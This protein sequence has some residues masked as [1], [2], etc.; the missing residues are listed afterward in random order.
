MPIPKKAEG[1]EPNLKSTKQELLDAYHQMR[2]QLE[3]KDKTQ[4]KPE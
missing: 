4:L 3:E 1:P 2:E